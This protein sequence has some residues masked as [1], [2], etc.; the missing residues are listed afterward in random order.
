AS[1]GTGV[2]SVAVCAVGLGRAGPRLSPAR[3]DRQSYSASCRP[4]LRIG[5]VRSFA[6]GRAV[7]EVQMTSTPKNE[8]RCREVFPTTLPADVLEAIHGGRQHENCA[9]ADGNVPELY[10]HFGQSWL[11]YTIEISRNPCQRAILY[12]TRNM[13]AVGAGP[14][15]WASLRAHERAH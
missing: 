7:K 12:D 1:S 14:N 3:R 8:S 2:A 5:S 9:D 15:D 11:G 6:D 10:G 13:S 4:E